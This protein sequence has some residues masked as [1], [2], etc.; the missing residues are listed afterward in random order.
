[1]RLSWIETLLVNS[2]PRR[3]LQRL[4]EVPALLRLGGMLPPGA[5]ALEIGCG[6]GYGTQLI[7]NRFGAAQVDAID[8]D[9]MMI[10]RARRRLGRFGDR[11]NLIVGDAAD[12]GAALGDGAATYDAVFDFATVHHVEDWRAALAEVARVLTMCGRFYFDEVTAD[13]LATRTYR[14]LFDHPVHD[15][16]T[17]RQFVEELH[18]LGLRATGRWFTVDRGHYLL[19]VAHRSP[20]APLDVPHIA[21]N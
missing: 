17:A 1:M 4:Y 13:A 18:R 16:F 20:A 3:A 2:R 14:V 19:G 12:L 5:R 21:T 9:P 6:S 15:R 8:L 10:D 11:V 7:L